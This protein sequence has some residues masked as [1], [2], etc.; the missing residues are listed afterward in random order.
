M[1][2]RPFAKAN[3][4]STNFSPFVL[5]VAFLERRMIRPLGPSAFPEH[6]FQIEQ[7]EAILAL[8]EGIMPPNF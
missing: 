7:L 2:D 3:S 1:R 6:P 5:P 8:G 4:S